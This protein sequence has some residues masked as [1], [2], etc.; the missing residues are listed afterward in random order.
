MA[1][2]LVAFSCTFSSHSWNSRSGKSHVVSSP[3]E[4]LT[5]QETE[6]HANGH[7]NE[8][9]NK[10]ISLSH[11]SS[12][13]AVNTSSLRRPDP[14]SP[15]YGTSRLLN[16]RNWWQNKYLLFQTAKPWRDLLH[17]KQYQIYF[18]ISFLWQVHAR[19]KWGFGWC[20]VWYNPGGR[21]ESMTSLTLPTTDPKWF[22][23]TL[24]W[25][26]YRWEQSRQFKIKMLLSSR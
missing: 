9:G 22:Q 21:C 24:S 16:P 20:N 18:L 1:S 17:S 2:L 7:L 4:R 19:T 13:M 11:K 15:S 23:E 5:K 8:L 3:K 25:I 12:E 10:S 14:Q 6:A 26:S